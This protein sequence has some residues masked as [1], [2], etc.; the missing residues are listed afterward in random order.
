[1]DPE[2]ARKLEAEFG[3]PVIPGSIADKD[4]RKEA[5]KK[6][7]IV[8]NT[9]AV[10]KESGAIEEFRKIN[11]EATYQLADEAKKQGAR[12]FVQLSSIMVYGF[13]YPPYVTEEGP[14]DGKESHYAQT[15]IEGENAILPL[16]QPP[17]FGVIILRPGDVYGPGSEP[18]VIRP[19]R[20]MDK[21]L[22]SLP[23]GGEGII[24]LCYVDNLSDSV[25]SAIEKKVYGIPVNITD[26]MPITWKEYFTDLF[27]IAGRPAPRSMPYFMAKGLVGI[28]API[29]KWT[30]GESPLSPEGIDFIMRPHPVSTERA[31]RLLGVAPRI[32]YK[33]ALENIQAWIR[34]KRI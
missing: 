4:T 9:A 21:G 33:K 14:L 10:M 2:R 23:S 32:D 6:V 26:G 28:L 19:L 34:E 22:F 27:Q 18:W 11:V 20:V 15:K 31:K 5:L 17:K 3:I 8:I 7:G 16:N 13:H 29:L 24:N 25:F 30:Q 1:M 12:V